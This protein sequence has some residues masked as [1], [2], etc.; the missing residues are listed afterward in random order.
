MACSDWVRENPMMWTIS[1]RMAP[2]GRRVM[3]L[4]EKHF[5]TPEAAGQASQ[6]QPPADGKR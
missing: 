1:T 6:S 2:M 5:E 4:C 3:G